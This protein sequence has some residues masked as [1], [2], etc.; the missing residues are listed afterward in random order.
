VKEPEKLPETARALVTILETSQ[1]ISAPLGPLQALEA[2]QTH[3]QLDE[4]KAAEWKATVREA[5]R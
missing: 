5:R 2:L 4:Q 1:P 3:L